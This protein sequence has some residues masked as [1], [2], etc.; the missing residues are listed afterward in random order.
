MKTV[1]RASAA[2]VVTTASVA[3]FMGAKPD[4]DRT[5]RSIPN[6]DGVLQ[7]ARLLMLLGA[8][9]LIASLPG[10]LRGRQGAR[11]VALSSAVVVAAASALDGTVVSG[12]ALGLATTALLASSRRAFTAPAHGPRTAQAVV[13]MLA[14][15]AG[16]FVY[17]ALGSY[18]LDDNFHE[19][20]TIA[21]SLYDGLRMMALLPTSIVDPATA[22]GAWF[23][24]SVRVLV[25]L[26]VLIGLARVSVAVVAHAQRADDDRR[27]VAELLERHGD[28]ALAPFLLLDD[29]SWVFSPDRNA[30]VGYRVVASTAVALG[31]PVGAPEARRAAVVAFRE[32]CES[33]G[34]IPAFHQ[35]RDDDRAELE[36]DG[37]R[38]L[39][40]GE[41][42]VV[43]LDEFDLSGSSMKSL[44]S[45]LKRVERVGST[46]EVLHDIDDATM[47]ELQDVSDAWL[48]TGGHRERTFSV[49]RFDPDALRETEIAVVRDADDRVIAFANILPEHRS[50]LGN[51][52]L[53]RRRPDCVNGVMEFLFVRLID[54]FHARGCSGM[55]LGLAPLSGVD[56]TGFVERMLGAL[57]AH[58]GSTFNFDGLRE[59][60][61]KWRPRWEPRYIAYRRERDLPALA[62]GIARVGELRVGGTRARVHR[63]LARYPFTA[64]MLTF[65]LW[66]SVATALDHRVQRVLVGTFGLS[67]PDLR[68]LE[69]WRV[70]TSSLVSPRAGFVWSNLV[71][72]VA[73]LPIAERRF[74]SRRTAT[75]FFA[76]DIVASLLALAVL[77]TAGMLGNHAATA[78]LVLRDTGQSAGAWA[79]AAALA[80]TVAHPRARLAWSLA[81]AVV[82][83]GQL[84][85]FQRLFDLQH[86][87][88][89]LVG[90]IL[91]RRW[92]A[93]RSPG[94]DT[95]PAPRIRL[96]TNVPVT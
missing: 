2:L 69:L 74:G 41:E 67:Q 14:G 60:K 54:L 15:L 66:L 64:S 63:A 73:V 75:A 90:V 86:V 76:G 92:S 59:F 28:S 81:V 45:T 53:M 95:T 30:V 47:R 21:G 26:V 65:A 23:V 7:D 5:V 19:S 37:F 50:G 77:Q 43:P 79:L 70:L 40:I 91:A 10:L 25:F 55:T 62:I 49:G 18:L 39:K 87:V 4:V 85:A 82:L 88:A 61:A 33:H 52:D 80:V 58:G 32:R 22:H 24:D 72:L 29:K 20:T 9:G 36:S 44:R 94:Q 11:W 8:A 56:G 96:V 16:I 38:Y 51:V 34:W 68:H 6:A 12:V 46:F 3:A 35:V 42:A 78:D 31:G 84:A 89:A 1:R 17:A 93:A 13:G 71:L 83:L 57:R 48:A 27:R